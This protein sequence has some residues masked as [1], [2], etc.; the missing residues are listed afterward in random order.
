MPERD[1]AYRGRLQL[2]EKVQ[3]LVERTR[4]L[5]GKLQEI[6]GA[7]ET[8]PALPG[9]VES[10]LCEELLANPPSCFD[11]GPLRM[12]VSCQALSLIEGGVD[13]E[14]AIKRAWQTAIERCHA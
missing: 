7:P 12:L 11:T 5:A 13:K 10:G 1:G 3:E 14:E 2:E 4:Q 8:H 6:I 9:E